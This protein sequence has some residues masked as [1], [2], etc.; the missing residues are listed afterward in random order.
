MWIET[1][2]ATKATGRKRNVD[3]MPCKLGSCFPQVDEENSGNSSFIDVG[4]LA[5]MQERPPNDVLVRK[6]RYV[7]FIKADT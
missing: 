2:L 3:F 5:Q 4:S 7:V 1:Q 6:N